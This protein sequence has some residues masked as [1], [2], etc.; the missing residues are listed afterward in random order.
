MDE[1]LGLAP[2]EVKL[3]QIAKMMLEQHDQDDW[4][5]K[6][7]VIV[8][9]PSYGS[10][11]IHLDDEEVREERDKYR[12]KYRLLVRE[13]GSISGFYIADRDFK[14]EHHYA[15]WIGRFHG[16]E[17]KLRAYHACGTKLIIDKDQVENQHRG[18]VSDD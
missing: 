12:C 16:I 2:K 4:G 8:D 18:V 14:G 13:D 5:Q 7:T 17:Q 10:M 15:R 9:E 1:L 11:W 3:S 6:I